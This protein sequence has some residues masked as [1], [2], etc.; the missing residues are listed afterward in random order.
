MHSTIERKLV[1]DIFTERDYV[2]ILQ[3][4]RIRPSSY[5][6]KQMK[7]TDFMK[8]DG[9]YLNNIRPGKKAGDPT[10][11]NLRGLRY[12]SEGQVSY[13]LSL[14]EDATWEA[15]PQRIQAINNLQWN[16]MFQAAHP[17]KLR[18]Y[19]DLQSM[20]PVIPADCHH[21]FDTLPHE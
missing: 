21:F 15:L 13:K 14:S 6:V 1:H 18:K 17:I 19:N 16:A 11:H 3:S 10:V 4:A 8:M 20:K 2:V 7:Y 12:E 5:K 9:A